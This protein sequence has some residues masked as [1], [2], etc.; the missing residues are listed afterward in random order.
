MHRTYKKSLNNHKNAN[1]VDTLE[2]TS[3]LPTHRQHVETNMSGQIG[4][5]ASVSTRL[6]KPVRPIH[7]GFH[8][9]GRPGGSDR[10]FQTCGDAHDPTC[11][12]MLVS[13]CWRG[14]GSQD[15]GSNVSTSFAFLWLFNDFLYVLWISYLL[16]QASVFLIQLFLIQAKKTIFLNQRRGVLD[17]SIT[18]WDPTPHMACSTLF[19][20]G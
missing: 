4:T 13:T 3:W 1:F 17:I 14:V 8:K 9:G 10:F 15:V 6:K 12:D 16:G 2:P 19:Y 18:F 11:P 20:V 5:C 7:K